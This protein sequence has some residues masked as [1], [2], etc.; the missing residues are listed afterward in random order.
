MLGSAFRAEVTVTFARRK[1][2]HLLLPGRDLCGEVVLADIGIPD[3]VVEGLGTKTFENRPALWVA[4][5]TRPA[6]A[7][8]Q[9]RRG[10]V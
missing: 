5:F 10:H 3:A 1:P 2:G 8:H 4:A 9:Y 7:T 6:P